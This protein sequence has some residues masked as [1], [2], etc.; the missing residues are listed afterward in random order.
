MMEIMFDI[1]KTIALVVLGYYCYRS[2]YNKGFED[3]VKSALGGVEDGPIAMEHTH[4]GEDNMN[5]G[6]FTPTK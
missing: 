2:G 5:D 3:G 1:L 4:G 6:D